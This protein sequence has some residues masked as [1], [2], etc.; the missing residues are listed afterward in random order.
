MNETSGN[1]VYDFDKEM[2][3][4]STTL[5]WINLTNNET[6]EQD[7]PDEPGGANR[8]FDGICSKRF[9]KFETHM[10]LGYAEI[11]HFRKCLGNL[12]MPGV[13]SFT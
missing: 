3:Q 1:Q 12:E 5:M 6:L 9:L 13:S 4:T 2:F 11:R 10:S 8:Y 7:G